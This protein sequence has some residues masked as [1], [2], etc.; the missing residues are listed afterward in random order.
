MVMEQQNTK[1]NGKGKNKNPPTHCTANQTL[2][3]PEDLM[4]LRYTG[5]QLSCKQKCSH[6]QQMSIM[7]KEYAC[8]FSS[9][10]IHLLLL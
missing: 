6:N 10:N 9:H 1:I 4:Q 3:I 8:Q 2:I 7:C 5:I